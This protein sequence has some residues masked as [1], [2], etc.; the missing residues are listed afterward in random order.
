MMPFAGGIDSLSN[1]T[2]LFSAA[3]AFFYL[4]MRD[5]PPSPRRTAMKAGSVA[6]LALLAIIEGG[7]VLLVAA[8]ALSAMGDAFLAHEGEKRFLGGLAS[9]L[10]AHLVYV[11][12][13]WQA[14]GGVEIWSAQPWRLAGPTL[15][16]IGTAILLRRLLRTVATPLRLPVAA[17]AAAIVAM[18][19]TASTVSAPPV[20]AGAALFVLS[21]MILAV[22]RF[23]LRPASP[24]RGST[25]LAVWVFYYLAQL[26]IT[27]GFLL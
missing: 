7:P 23:L 14:G 21:D 16:A 6:L 11:A 22:S 9:F 10:V 17:Y 24:Y 12:L 13:F 27:L 25:G 2:L 8:L 18:V 15:A 26:A 19:L 5:R 20:L 1:G 3:A 4:L